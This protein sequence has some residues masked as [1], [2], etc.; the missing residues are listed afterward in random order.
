MTAESLASGDCAALLAS[1]VR[2]EEPRELGTPGAL[3]APLRLHCQEPLDVYRLGLGEPSQGFLEAQGT[4]Y[5]A[6]ALLIS[7]SS[8]N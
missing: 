2:R 1:A 7:Q 6:I 5:W 3:C 8:L 4:F